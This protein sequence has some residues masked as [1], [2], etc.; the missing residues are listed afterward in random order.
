MY[1]MQMEM[2]ILK[3]RINVLK[4]ELR[5][6]IHLLRPKELLFQNLIEAVK[7]DRVIFKKHIYTG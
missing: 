2:D 1:D 5:L 4:K 7:M 3:E 6:Y